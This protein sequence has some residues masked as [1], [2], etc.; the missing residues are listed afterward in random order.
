MAKKK[1]INECH[2]EGYLYEHKLEMKQTGPKSKNPGIDYIRGSIDIATDEALTNIVTV[3]YTY[4]VPTTS[5]GGPNNTYSVLAN[6]LN[7]IYGT[8]MG[9]GQERAIKVRI[10]CSLNLNEFYNDKDELVSSKRNEGGFIHVVEGALAENE[11]SRNT[12][13]VDMVITNVIH[14]DADEEKE[15]PEKAIVKGCIFDFRGALLPVEFTA[16]N[17]GA[18]AYF[19]GLE[20]SK[21]NPV[22][23]N[24]WGQQVSN[25]VVKRKVIESAFGD[26]QIQEAKYSKKD[27]VITGSLRV[28]Y[29]WDTEET[30]TAEEF[31]KM[32]SDRATVL[33]TKKQERDEYKAAKTAATQPAIDKFDF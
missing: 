11:D 29:E 2:I 30:L 26:D 6:I 16:V 3:H 22:F 12:F 21:S 24:I 10:D 19:E 1:F 9:D 15:L 17:S 31:G 5:K 25:T 7:G 33:A 18:I 8:V 28:P 20:A 32:C 13:K 23:T 14:V 4:V 27:F